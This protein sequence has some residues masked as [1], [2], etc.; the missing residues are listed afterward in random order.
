MKTSSL[1]LIASLLG[2][3]WL[4]QGC[5]R[6]VEQELPEFEP[7]LALN[8][9]VA[10][11]DPWRVEFGNLQPV[12]QPGSDPLPEGVVQV[13]PLGAPPV[14]L[15][16]DSLDENRFNENLYLSET[17][18]VEPGPTY[19]VSASHPGYDSVRAMVSA[20]SPPLEVTLVYLD[21]AQ[22]DRNGEPQP[23]VRVSWRD[24]APEEEN[25]FMVYSLL[26]DTVFG[27]QT[28]SALL[29]EDE[30]ATFRGS[31]QRPE[32]E[33]IGRSFSP[34]FLTDE[35]FEDGRYTL[36]MDVIIP[37]FPLSQHQFLDVAVA[38][39]SEDFYEFQRVYQLQGSFEN[40]PFAEPAPIL[41]NVEGGQGLVATYAPV[42]SRV[43]LQP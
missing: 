7:Q 14:S 10:L 8:A 28:Y 37:P 11:G 30:A 5:T 42:W 12:G 39:V 18:R 1:C 4:S 22:L 43:A 23:L 32:D 6:R 21:S 17:L 2:L 41:S 25:Y 40:D 20:P 24:P 33:E 35:R 34:T 29:S 19:Q 15:T 36:E 27:V 3:L 9:V 16:R 26:V 38:T 31:L 13:Q